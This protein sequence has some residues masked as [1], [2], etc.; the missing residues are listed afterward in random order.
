MVS[1]PNPSVYQPATTFICG[2]GQ[3]LTSI[4]YQA[5]PEREIAGNFLDEI[6]DWLKDLTQIQAPARVLFA[7]RAAHDA[8]C[9]WTDDLDKP[10]PMKETTND[11]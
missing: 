3:C 2:T 8:A 6:S 9:W 1:Q 4:S 5:R 7:L 11:H 10:R